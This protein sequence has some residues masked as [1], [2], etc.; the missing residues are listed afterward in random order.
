MGHKCCEDATCS[1]WQWHTATHPNV[2]TLCKLRGTSSRNYSP[3]TGHSTLHL[4]HS[5]ELQN[6]LTRPKHA[7][8]ARTC[9]SST[10]QALLQLAISLHQS[11]STSAVRMQRAPCGSGTLPP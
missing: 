4:D 3:V 8:L 10:A 1:V 5:T 11:V 9:K 6:W 7:R 2:M